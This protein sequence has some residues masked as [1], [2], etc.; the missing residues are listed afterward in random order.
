[1]KHRYSTPEKA[2]ETAAQSDR[3]T[4]RGDEPI[5]GS[6]GRV[7]DPSDHLPAD[8]WAPEPDTKKKGPEI[9][10]RIKPRVPLGE[11]RPNAVS[12][13]NSYAEA[14]RAQTGRTRL[15]KKSMMGTDYHANSSPIVPTLDTTTGRQHGPRHYASDYRIRERENYQYGGSGSPSPTYARSPVERA[16]PPVPGKVPIEREGNYWEGDALSEELRSIDIG[17]GAGGKGSAR[18]RG[19]GF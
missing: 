6:D 18:R 9:T 7:I 11:A 14:P 16:P 19:Y 8:T 4:K 2:M 12:M 5:I 10:V 15:Q 13:P 1:M 3:D 17:V